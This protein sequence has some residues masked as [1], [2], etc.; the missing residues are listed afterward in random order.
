[1]ERGMEDERKRKK[2]GIFFCYLVCKQRKKIK[3]E[4]KNKSKKLTKT[5]SKFLHSP[6]LIPSYLENDI[7]S[8]FS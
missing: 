2:N 6:I 5:F 3:E 7:F 4:I 1:M 8:L